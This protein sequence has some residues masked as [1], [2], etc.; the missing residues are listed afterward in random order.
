MLKMLFGALVVLLLVGYDVITTEDIE[1]ASDKVKETVNAGASYVKE[2]TDPSLM[3]QAKDV[4][5][6]IDN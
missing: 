6:R 3:D 2:K 4:V 5:K 1:A